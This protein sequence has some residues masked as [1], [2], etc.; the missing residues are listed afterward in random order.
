M[1]NLKKTFKEETH[2]TP[3]QNYLFSRTKSVI[4]QHNI[5]RKPTPIYNL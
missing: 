1:I 3:E 4:V 5:F 2:Y